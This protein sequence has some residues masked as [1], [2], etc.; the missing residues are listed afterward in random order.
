MPD[1]HFAQKFLCPDCGEVFTR[2][3]ME[4]CP[5]DGSALAE[6]VVDDE[7]REDP[8]IGEVLDERFAIEE[9]LGE[10]SMGRVYRAKQTSVDRD[11]AVKTVHPDHATDEETVKRFHREARAIS[12]FSHPNIVRL[13]DFGQDLDRGTL[14]LA[15]EYID[16]YSVR[17][18]VDRG[19]LTPAFTVH[20][21]IQVAGALAEVHSHEVVH[22]DVK[23]E[24]L[25]IVPLTDGRVEVKLLDFGIA[26]ALRAPQNLTETGAVFGTPHYL[27]PEQAQAEE[28][29]PYSDVYSLGAVMFAMLTGRHPV[30]AEDP[31]E[32][33]VGHVRGKIPSVAEVL[34]RGAVSDHLN[35]LVGNML[36][37]RPE[38]RPP[39]ILRV[40]DVLETIA[41][42]E[43]YETPE[44]DPSVGR[45]GMFQSFVLE[46]SVERNPADEGRGEDAPGADSVGSGGLAG[47]ISS[48]A[49]RTP[50][51]SFEPPPRS[52]SDEPTG[53]AAE[54]RDGE[55]VESRRG[56]DLPNETEPSS[57]AQ[58][59]PFAVAA[60]LVVSLG[61]VA[62]LYFAFGADAEVETESA[63]D[64]RAEPVSEDGSSG[65]AP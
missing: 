62:A 8:L 21:G 27:S 55:E 46:R 44:V 38:D 64:P 18:L 42:L 48:A 36:S 39:D 40:R 17:A 7:P 58:S 11:V 50:P 63:S 25:M 28:V 59:R 53:A 2:G 52:E 54:E 30:D 43:E 12:E 16:G 56:R 9:V 3:E 65:A 49:A 13:V 35:W 24:N 45:Q 60:V 51:E 29:G 23:P 5:N 26:H 31:M 14:Y 57:A 33:M 61:V 6:F 1:D 34:G 41:S 20:L 32:V 47:E 4:H 37:T 19:R 22:R 10:G 15:M